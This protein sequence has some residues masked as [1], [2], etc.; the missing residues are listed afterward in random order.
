MAPVCVHVRVCARTRV[1]VRGHEFLVLFALA[2]LLVV[3]VPCYDSTAQAILS[4]QGASRF[5]VSPPASL[6]TSTIPLVSGLWMALSTA[7]LSSTCPTG[8]TLRS[9]SK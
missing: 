1:C 3:G 4:L 8:W 6:T 5:W 9:L 7:D 2:S